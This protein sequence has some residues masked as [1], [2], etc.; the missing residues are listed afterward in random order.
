MR[1]LVAAVLLASAVLLVGQV[2][3]TLVGPMQ[4]YVTYQVSLTGQQAQPEI[5][6]LNESSQPT[7][8]SGLVQITITVRSSEQNATYSNTV[9]STSL[10]EIFPYI[11]DINN[12]SISYGANGVS[13]AVKAENTGSA[14]ITFNG[15]TYTGTSYQVSVSATYL[16]MAL[17]ITGNGTV[18]TLPSGLV[19]S[20]RLEQIDGNSISAQ[21]LK[22]NLPVTVAAGSS[23]PV[24]LALV[25]IGLLAAIAFAVPSIFIRL[26]KK[27][28]AETAPST[29]PKSEEKP[30]YWVD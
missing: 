13:V 1:F 22:T 26:R 9:N 11:V 29:P 19:Y 28:T 6:L 30:S 2:S 16:P 23:L 17:D 24:G 15:G 25:S 8:Q 12:E 27:P 5:L 4:G 10:P 21:L 14:K 3:A 20:V 18:V 7:S